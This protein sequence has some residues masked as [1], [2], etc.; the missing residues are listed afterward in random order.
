M[1]KFEGSNSAE[2]V[3]FLRAKK[4]S[5]R[6]HVVHLRHV[7]EPYNVSWKSASLGKIICRVSLP[8]I[9]PPFAAWS[10]RIAERHLAAKVGTGRILYGAGT[11]SLQA[12]VHPK[13]RLGALNMKEEKE[14]DFLNTCSTPWCKESQHR[15][16]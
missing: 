1:P 4:S 11:I 6:S 9:V 2:A 12:A 14:P 5:A 13:C 7:K 10:S 16:S 15:I 3:G 8:Q